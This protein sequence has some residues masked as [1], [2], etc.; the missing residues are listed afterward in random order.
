M[1]PLILAVLLMFGAPS[2]FATTDAV[3]NQALATLKARLAADK[4][5]AGRLALVESFKDF[6]FDRL[7]TVP[8]DESEAGKEAFARLNEIESYVFMMKFE[9]LSPA[10]CAHA[11]SRIST[12]SATN[13][14]YESESQINPS[15]PGVEALQLL[16]AICQP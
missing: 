9:K 2:A 16:K 14:D 15:K 8:L 5:P 4:T 12:S 7:Q 11:Y 1:R 13:L 6:L 10:E 3:T